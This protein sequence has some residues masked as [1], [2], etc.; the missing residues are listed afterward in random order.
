MMSFR[1]PCLYLSLFLFAVGSSSQAQVPGSGQAARG[2]ATLE[3]KGG[4]LIITVDKD[5]PLAQSLKVLVQSQNGDPIDP[6]M[7]IPK[8]N[9]PALPNTDKYTLG[10]TT[11]AVPASPKADGKTAS[12]VVIKQVTPQKPAATLGLKVGDTITAYEVQVETT[13]AEGVKR[14]KQM[15]PI[16]TPAQLEE[17]INIA[18]RKNETMKLAWTRGGKQQEPMYITPVREGTVGP[19]SSAPAMPN[20]PNI[21]QLQNLPTI[22]R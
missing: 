3:E 18:G 4:K 22:P 1:I 19:A 9:A 16:Q 12:G 13:T 10:M 21:P 7:F 14:V 6:S 8:M 15:M 20:L 5:S 17:A 11:E 2:K